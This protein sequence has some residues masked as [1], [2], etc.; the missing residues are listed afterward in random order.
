MSTFSSL[1]HNKEHSDKLDVAYSFVNDNI[2]LIIWQ[3][4]DGNEAVAYL[5]INEAK[6]IVDLIQQAIK[7]VEKELG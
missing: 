7:S 4:D 6:H 1:C 2:R 5:N 3:D